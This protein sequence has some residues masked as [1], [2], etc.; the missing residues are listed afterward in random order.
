D[1]TVYVVLCPELEPYKL[2]P[3]S[4]LQFVSAVLVFPADKRLAAG[5]TGFEMTSL[6][7]HMNLLD[8]SA[9]PI[10]LAQK[11]TKFQLWKGHGRQMSCQA[12]GKVLE[13]KCRYIAC[14]FAALQVIAFAPLSFG[15]MSK[16]LKSCNGKSEIK[17]K[18]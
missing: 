1:P 16:N 17:Q 15:F 14:D 3:Y 18:F 9:P 13:N 5:H 12:A 6:L 11:M 2:L 8:S 10:A 4:I 7:P